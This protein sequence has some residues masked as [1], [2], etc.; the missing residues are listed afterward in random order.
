MGK[1][2][3]LNTVNMFGKLQ[4][5]E[6][7]TKHNMTTI[8]AP[9]CIDDSKFCPTAEAL[10]NINGTPLTDEQI[11]NSYDFPNGKDNGMSLP[12]GRGR[13]NDITE[14]AS[15]VQKNNA[16]LSNSFNEFKEETKRKEYQ[17]KRLDMLN[18]VK[19]VVNDIP[20]IK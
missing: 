13:F 5:F 10:K 15:E 6:V 17:K 18:A 12:I 14:L 16:N 3:T 2:I 19:D 20:S 7:D 8:K 11:A 1:Y 4:R 9:Y